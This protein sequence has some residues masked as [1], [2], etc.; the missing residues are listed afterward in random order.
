MDE[1]IKELEEQIQYHSDLY[2]NEGEP[3]ITDSEFDELWDELTSLDPD[4]EILKAVGAIAHGTKVKHNTVMGSLSKVKTQDDL[5]KWTSGGGSASKFSVTPKIDGMAIRLNYYKGKLVQA[6]TRGDGAKG[7]DVTENVKLIASIPNETDQGF[8]G[9]IRGEVYMKKSVFKEL[10]EQGFDLTNTRNAA[11]GSVMQ[12]DPRETAKRRLDF[13]AYDIIYDADCETKQTFIHEA[14]KFW[15]LSALSGFEVVPAR[16]LDLDK[17]DAY[18]YDWE[19]NKREQLDY[20]IDGMV[21]GYSLLE[22]QEDAG[23][24]GKRPKGKIAWKFEDEQKNAEL[25]FIDWQVGRTGKLT[26]VANIEA[27]VL[28]GSTVRKL[29]LHNK[30]AVV[31]LDIRVGD[32]LTVRKANEVIPNLVCVAKHC[33]NG[34]LEL[35][36]ECPA[37]AGEIEDDGVNLVCMNVDCSSQLES[38][39]EHYLKRIEVMGVGPA[40]VHNLVSCGA[41]KDL[42]DLYYLDFD[43]V[44]A[45]IGSEVTTR[46]MIQGIFEKDNLPLDVFLSALGIHTLGRTNSKNIAQKFRTLEA[47]RNTSFV[48]MSSLP[49]IGGSSAGHIV[50]GLTK[51]GPVIDRILEVIDVAPVE[52]IE[53]ALT[54]MSF[55]LTGSMSRPRKSIAADIEAAGGEVKSSVGRGLTYLVQNEDK[56]SG[57]SKK[58]KANGTMVINEDT[59]HILMEG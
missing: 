52:D 47:V 45:G 18:L 7:T 49:G 34:L 31:D 14:E 54:G 16:A 51:M 27:T 11:S 1:R 26:P 20:N 6:A 58:A 30:K 56:E 2:Y 19:H 40:M 13:F 57:K 23:W 41:V 32:I 4:N 8:S 55:C 12:K 53:G 5:E 22:T 28:D 35:P 17:V 24:S 21:L 10:N 46:K 50:D 43:D 29:T 25:L 15:A 38:R 9:E 36:T 59:L 48:M 33:E 44:N 42:A 37:C 3:E 39:V